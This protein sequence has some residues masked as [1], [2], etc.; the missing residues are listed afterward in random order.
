MLCEKRSS[1]VDQIRNNAV[2]RVRPEAGKLKAVACLFLTRAALFVLILSIISGR[3]GIIFSIRAIGDNKNLHILKQS[4]A[5]LKRLTLI[6]VDLIER[7][8]NWNT[9]AFQLNMDERQAIDQHRNII[10]V[11]VLCALLPADGILMKNLQAVI[12]NVLLVNK[13]DVFRGT[14]ITGQHLYVVLL[15]FARLFDDMLI[16][17]SHTVF[18][19]GFPLRIRELIIV[20]LLQSA[21]EIGNQLFFRVDRQIFVAL[22]TEQPDK[23]LFKRNFALV[24][25]RPLFDRLIFCDN[26]IF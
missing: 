16:R 14:V 1:K 8:T 2:M 12:V 26:G 6:T 5:S 13:G 11:I 3:I 23:F 25:V 19:K 18:E 15:N 24:A 7:L 17:I 9:T 22:F 21:S 4:A 20:Q 10:T